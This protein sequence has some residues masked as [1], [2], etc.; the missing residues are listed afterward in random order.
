VD[1]KDEKVFGKGKAYG[2]KD[3]QGLVYVLWIIRI[4]CVPSFYCR[5]TFH[6]IKDLKRVLLK[7][8]YAIQYLAQGKHMH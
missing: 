7:T 1:Y 3:Q 8:K 4:K 2:L 5:L 6:R